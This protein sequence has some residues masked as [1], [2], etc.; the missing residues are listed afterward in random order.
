MTD[1]VHALVPA[2]GRGER[3]GA[4]GP[5]VLV[6]LC[7]RPAL[8]WTLSRLVDAGVASL[9]VALPR[10]HVEQAQLQVERWR[11]DLAERTSWIVGG[12]ERQESVGRCLERSAASASDWILV[13]DGARAAIDPRDV[14]AVVS[15]AREHGAAILGRPVSD[16]LKRVVEG[17][18]AATVDRSGLFRA[19]TPQVCRRE[20]LER[21]LA[22]ARRRGHIATDECGLLEAAGV[23]VRAV[24]ARF[25]NPK[26]TYPADTPLFEA[27]LCS[28]S[29]A[30]TEG[31]GGGAAPGLV[32]SAG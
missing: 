30:D 24:V 2:A 32:G 19:E 20:A 6:P 15:A 3:F 18:V 26:L 4:A 31:S 27:L 23:A 8:V 11:P 16:T 1:R 13:H 10:E 14:A 9:V 17:F 29:T 5:K 22:E 28:P 7:S 21:A 12:A 25:P